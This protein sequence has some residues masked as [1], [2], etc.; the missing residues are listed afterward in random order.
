[1]STVFYTT[2]PTAIITAAIQ[3]QPSGYSL[4]SS[5]GSPIKAGGAQAVG[6][7]VLGQ[8]DGSL[9]NATVAVYPSVNASEAYFGRLVSNLK[10]LPGYTD[11]T[12][13]LSSYQGYGGCYGYGEDVDG[14]AVVNGVCAKGNVILQLHLVSGKAFDDLE[15]DMAS[16]M[17]ALYQGTG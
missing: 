17:A 6:W 12:S 4:E 1:M 10:Q 15:S 3:T 7:A 16:L 5:S 8:A 14:T 9:A 2:S 13:S 11:V